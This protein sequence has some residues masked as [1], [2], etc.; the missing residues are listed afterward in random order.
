[1]VWLWW[2]CTGCWNVQGAALG[3]IFKEE[4]EEIILEMDRSVSETI[5]FH[6]AQLKM[7][8]NLTSSSLTDVQVLVWSWPS[9]WACCCCYWLSPRWRFRPRDGVSRRRAEPPPPPEPLRTSGTSGMAVSTGITLCLLWVKGQV[10]HHD[11]VKLE[12]KGHRAR[13]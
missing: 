5:N 7:N 6:K 11:D 9:N 8:L 2:R 10:Q 3:S 4:K 12:V 13:L 1:M